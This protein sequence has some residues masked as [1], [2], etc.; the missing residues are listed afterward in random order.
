MPG[1]QPPGDVGKTIPTATPLDFSHISEINI[2][3]TITGDQSNVYDLGAFAPG[4]RIIATVNATAGSTLDPTA[5]IFDAN[6]ELIWINDDVDLAA[7]NLNSRIDFV[8]IEDIDHYYLAIAKFFLDATGGTYSGSVRVERGGQVPVLPVQTLLLNFD[9]GPVDILSE[10]NYDLDPFDAAD[11]DAAY[12]DQTAVIK[13]KIVEVMIENFAGTGL[14]IVS[15]DD[16]PS[17]TPGTFSVMHFGAF[18][19]TKFGVADSV[20]VGN[21]DYCDDGIVF[22]DSFDTPFAVQPTVEGIGIAIGNVAAHEA[23]HLL[24]LNHTSDVTD[25]MDSTGTAST[26]LEDQE[27]KTAPLHVSIFP[28]GNQNGPR[29]LERV[30]PQQP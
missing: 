26:L 27:F 12:A 5:A 3:G 17:L 25:L 13:A 21:I 23:G 7:N 10:G 30:I 16:N 4:D 8:V 6:E 29:L 9:G 11:I 24:G 22:T 20:D 2:F 28:F 14:V 1:S 15:S 19:P 18:S